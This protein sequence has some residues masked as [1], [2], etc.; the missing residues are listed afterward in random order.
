VEAFDAIANDATASLFIAVDAGRVVGT[1]QINIL[2][3]LTQGGAPV[4]QIEAVVV[5]RASRGQG[6]GTAMM[7]FAIEEARR[8]GCTRVQ[9]T[10]QKR[11][12]RA[13]GFY[14][15]L[16]FARTHEG[17]VIM[18]PA[19]SSRIDQVLGAIL[20]TERTRVDVGAKNEPRSNLAT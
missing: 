9:L 17:G 2:R 19:P 20:E 4:A 5:A 8:L 3:H 13:H 15:R 16:G 11:R 14:E 7:R 6:V 10:S 1:F 18:S 12:D